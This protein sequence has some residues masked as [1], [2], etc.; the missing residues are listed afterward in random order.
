MA[1]GAYSRDKP[2]IREQAPSPLWPQSSVE[3]GGDVLLSTY[4]NFTVG[5]PLAR[6]CFLANGPGMSF[7]S[8]V[9]CPSLKLL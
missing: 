7:H 6:L 1:V 5:K 4:G 3:K 9:A 2:Y 8:G